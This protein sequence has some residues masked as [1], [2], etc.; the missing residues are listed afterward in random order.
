LISITEDNT[1]LR[2][3]LSTATAD[4]DAERIM[5]LQHA[6]EETFTQVLINQRRMQDHLARD[7]SRE[8]ITSAPYRT[9]K[10]TEAKASVPRRTAEQQNEATS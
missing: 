6:I 4:D 1:R 5:T 2:K 3:E 7:H 8:Q 9:Q 10:G